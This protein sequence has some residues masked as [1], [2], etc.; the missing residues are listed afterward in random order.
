VRI[1]GTGHASLRIDTAAA[2]AHMHREMAPNPLLYSPEPRFPKDAARAGIEG[3]FVKA[4]LAVDAAGSP[5]TITLGE[6]S[7]PG[8]FDEEARRTLARWR[9]TMSDAEERTFDVH[10]DFRR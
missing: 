2:L 5:R 1:T 8:Y 4:R 7:H 9:Y 6:V 10:L 3:G